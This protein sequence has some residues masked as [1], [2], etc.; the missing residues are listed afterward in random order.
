VTTLPVNEKLHP[1]LLACVDK[2]FTL[3]NFA[4]RVCRKD[5]RVEEISDLEL[6]VKFILVFA[7]QDRPGTDTVNAFAS[8]N[9]GLQGFDIPK[10]CFYNLTTAILELLCCLGRGVTSDSTR[11]ECAIGKKSVHDRGAC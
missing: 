1:Y 10:I 4:L 2:V 7:L 9:S 11:S 6:E 8:G 3:L 5:G